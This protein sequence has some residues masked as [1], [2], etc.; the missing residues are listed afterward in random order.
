MINVSM[1]VP[2]FRRIAKEA[3]PSL[4]RTCKARAHA[5]IEI[6]GGNLENTYTINVD[7]TTMMEQEKG[8]DWH[9]IS[10]MKL[11]HTTG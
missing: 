11:K 5:V 7:N 8:N 6:Q 10:I 2:N 4:V 3:P 9:N 1:V